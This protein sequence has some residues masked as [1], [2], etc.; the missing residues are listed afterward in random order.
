MTEPS[1]LAGDLRV[2]LGQLI[3]RL[4]AERRG[5]SLSQVTV[6]GRLDRHGSAGISDLAAA[7]RVRP[8]SMAGTVAALQDAGLVDRSPDP[9]DGRRSLIGLTAAGREALL[10]DRRRREDW[11]ADAI[12][13]DLSDAERRVLRE[14]TAL[15]ARLA[16]GE[17]R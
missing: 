5:L 3:R 8:Q 7:E 1:D 13:R 16:D 10:E 15:L 4:R 9:R 6:L 2:V 11:L 12:A 17:P 14:A